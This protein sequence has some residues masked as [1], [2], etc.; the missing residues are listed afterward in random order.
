MGGG[1]QNP[2]VRPL[3]WP[4]TPPTTQAGRTVGASQIF[5]KGTLL[6]GVQCD[7]SA[8]CPSSA[9]ADETWAELAVLMGHMIFITCLSSARPSLVSQLVGGHPRLGADH[10]VNASHLVAN[11]PGA[12][13]T[14]PGMN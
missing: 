6:Q 13:E 14:P 2:L 4:L 3:A 10:R 9:W 8:T 1:A 12:L 11:L 7:H 5:F